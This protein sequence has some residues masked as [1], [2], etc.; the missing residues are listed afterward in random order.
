M[1]ESASQ[2]TRKLPMLSRGVWVFIDQGVSSLTNFGLSFVALREL[3][4][5]AFGAF[6]WGFGVYAFFVALGRALVGEPLLI[7]YGTDEND[8]KRT[9]ASAVGAATGAGLLGSAVICG[10]AAMVDSSSL[11]TG[12]IALAIVMPGLLAQDGWRHVFFAMR[13]PGRALAND[14]VWFSAMVLGL[15]VLYLTETLTLWSLMLVWGL[16]AAMAASYGSFQ[17][18]VV[19]SLKAASLW[20]KINRDLWPRFGSEAV[21]RVG[22]PQLSLL[23][24]GAIAGLASLGSINGARVLLGPVNVLYLGVLAFGVP[25]GVRLLGDSAKKLRRFVYRLAGLL[26]LVSVMLGSVI[27]FL[28][29]DV[30]ESLVG[31]NWADVHVLLIPVVWWVAAASGIYAARTGLR[32]LADARASHGVQIISA[33][34]FPSGAVAGAYVGGARGAAVGLA[35]ANTLLAIVWLVAFARSLEKQASYGLF[36]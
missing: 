15:S 10:V 32:V 13:V 33:V 1:N 7:R 27:Y 4:L 17:M 20:L 14:T 36:A 24:V 11:R 19:P 25:E 6:T 5:S 9:A 8:P 30:G 3:D 29:A 35:L 12:L 26:A 18:R 28:P 16:A 23:A 22:V 31:E 21:L 2:A 34:V